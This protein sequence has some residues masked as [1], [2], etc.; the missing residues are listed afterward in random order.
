M[1]TIE[2]L[3]FRAKVARTFWERTRGLID[4]DDQVVK[5]VRNGF[6]FASCV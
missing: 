5:T 2:I 1:K 3:G 4:K 6:A